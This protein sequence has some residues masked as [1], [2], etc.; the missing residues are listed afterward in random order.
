MK[1]VKKF[2]YAILKI[3]KWGF[4]LLI[5]LLILSAIY[6]QFL[7]E[8]SETIETLS[9]AQKGYI[10]EAMNLQSELG[11]EI[12][13]VWPHP[14]PVIV[15][16]ERYAFLVGIQNPESGWKK[17]PAEELRGGE[18]KTV[19]ND[20][21]FGETYYRQEL[22]DPEITPENFTVKVGGEWA[23]TL[24][25]RE[26]AEVAFYNGFKEE[27]PPF[28]SQIFPYTIFWNLVMG[29]SEN[30]VTGL[31][32]ESFHAVQG[33]RVPER[34]ASAERISHQEFD[35]PWFHPDNE[36]GWKQEA[37]LLIQAYQAESDAERKDLV[38]TFLN[39]RDERREAAGL[40]PEQII[41]E[42]E[43]EWLEGV[44]K[45]VELKIGLTAA[46]KKNY[47]S[48]PEIR[49]DSDFDGYQSFQSYFEGQLGEVPR[50]AARD[51]ESRF[52]YV[53]MIEAFLLDQMQPGW[54]EQIFT[55]GVY[56]EDL[57]R[58]VTDG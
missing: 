49:K 34:L 45:Y 12:W 9:D 56:L 39:T 7:P 24:Q 53:G 26:Y 48:Y 46:E 27:L 35:Y 22:P 32:H 15:Y 5:S 3:L 18:W 50:A 51:G 58:G 6:N 10:A 52:Y 2:F 55:E 54:K 47:S 38:R 21:F 11:D 43:R 17:M 4:I 1:H 40:S 19:T 8:Q 41:Y 57:L 13:P 23:A 16:N 25:T 29:E 42:K 14:V 20:D 37:D 44:A 31:I 36:N 30:Y 33:I 28:I